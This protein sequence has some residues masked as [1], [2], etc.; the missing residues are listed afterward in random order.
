MSRE[1]GMGGVEGEG[2]DWLGRV[3]KRVE[4]SS[5]TLLMLMSSKMKMRN[6]R[7]SAIGR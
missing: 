1:G 7:A 2:R 6:W 3:T 4:T 5:R